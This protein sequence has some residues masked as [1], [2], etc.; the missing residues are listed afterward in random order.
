[1]EISK[2]YMSRCLELAGKG[3]GHVAPN[4]M[5]GAVIVHG[6][7]IIGEGFHRYSGGSHAEVD[8]IA[9]VRD[10]ALLRS[11]T[12][13]VNLEPCSH[14]GKTPPC[15][16]LIIQKKIPCVVIA[17]LDPYPEVA[18]RGV[19]MLRSAGVEVIMG[20]MER[21]AI[22]LNRFFITAHTARRPYI[23]LKWA[24]S[25][26]GFIDRKRNDV[27]ERPVVFSTP[28]TRMMVHKLRSEVQAVMVGTNTAILD[29]PSLTV[30]Y[31]SGKSPTRILID[32]DL[33]VPENYHLLDDTQRT[34]VF[35]KHNFKDARRR[36]PD[37]KNVKYIKIDD[38]ANMLN[39]IAT[40]LYKENIHSLLVEGG[41]RLH[42][43]F[44]EEGLWDEIIVETAPVRIKEGVKPASFYIHDGVQLVDR[45]I[46]PSGGAFGKRHSVV[47]RYIRRKV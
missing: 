27:S 45:Q 19:S 47:E 8:A 32:C 46:I 4:P 7:N 14:Y 37:K 17:C 35:T 12:L 44:I 15:A 11:S 9:S 41:A 6:G 43:S 1:M 30:R 18:G 34:F 23:I 33:R 13:Y 3:N 21:E 39:Y 25:E 10:T 38:S 22:D 42:R 29:N 5:V 28:V 36:D 40:N 24:Q 16:E 31:W 26:D 2:L 20:V